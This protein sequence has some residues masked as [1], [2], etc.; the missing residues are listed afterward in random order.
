MSESGELLASLIAYMIMGAF[1]CIVIGNI[2]RCFGLNHILRICI[3]IFVL[4]VFPF[5]LLWFIN[6]AILQLPSRWFIQEK[7][8]EPLLL[9]NITQ[10]QTLWRWM[11]NEIGKNCCSSFL[12][13]L[14]P[15]TAF[16]IIL[17]ISIDGVNNGLNDMELY[18]FIPSLVIY[19]GYYLVCMYRLRKQRYIICIPFFA[20]YMTIKSILMWIL[21][22]M[23]IWDFYPYLFFGLEVHDWDTM[24]TDI[25]GCTCNECEREYNKYAKYLEWY[26]KERK[27][28]LSIYINDNNVID[29]VVHYL[30]EM[31][32]PKIRY[33][34]YAYKSIKFEYLSDI[35]VVID[36]FSL[37]RNYI[38]AWT[39][40]KQLLNVKTY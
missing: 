17:V 19:L 1:A 30:N 6:H 3:T 13:P 28:V 25:C 5:S 34:S 10:T 11:E 7:D 31:E 23:I 35:D 4:L 36:T 20:I 24:Y 9:G 14:I 16:I 27:D 33:P 22:V 12:K 39:S 29:I 18:I 26:I 15:N 32:Y 40:H 8:H 38:E 2:A 21:F 37:N